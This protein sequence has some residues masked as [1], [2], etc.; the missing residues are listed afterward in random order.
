[1]TPVDLRTILSYE[2]F[3]LTTWRQST[4]LGSN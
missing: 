4:L 2:R 1:S 3:E